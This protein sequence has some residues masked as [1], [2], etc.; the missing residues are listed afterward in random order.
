MTARKGITG[1][2]FFEREYINIKWISIILNICTNI[3]SKIVAAA[4]VLQVSP[5]TSFIRWRIIGSRQIGELDG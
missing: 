1:I 2:I 3:M 5:C 4:I